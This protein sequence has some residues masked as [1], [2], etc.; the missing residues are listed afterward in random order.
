VAAAQRDAVTMLH[1][2]CDVSSVT[3]I[4]AASVA[5]GPS[6]WPRF[7]DVGS[8]SCTGRRTGKAQWAKLITMQ[9]FIRLRRA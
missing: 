5:T 6:R 1:H 9:Y 7:H 8:L 4:P 2:P 3:S